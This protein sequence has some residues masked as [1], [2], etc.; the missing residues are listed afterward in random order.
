MKYILITLLLGL[1]QIQAQK[2]VEMITKEVSFADNSPENIFVARNINGSIN[3]EAYNGKTIKIE[4]TKTISADNQTDIEKGKKEL[5]IKIVEKG[6][7]IILHP[8]A[9]YICF[10]E[11]YHGMNVNVNRS[12][13][14]EVPYHFKLEY[15]IKVPKNLN[16]D[17]STINEGDIVV[18]D[19]QA[20]IVKVGNIN[21]SIALYNIAGASEVHTINGTID[22]TY[23]KNPDKKS[24][25]S[26]INGDIE[27]NYLKN[28][29][30]NVTFESMHGDL[31]TDF[32]ISDY[33]TKSEKNTSTEKKG[34]KYT[35][36]STPLVQ[37]GNGGPRFEFK[38]LNGD[39]SIKKI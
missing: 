25:Y 12:N 7:K 33:I 21:G 5:N 31:Y 37:I 29:K 19:V 23:A 27:I 11:T 6:N 13:K 28:L 18:R 20:D 2:S 34:L 15:K 22:V 10:D 39:V 24:S 26:T 16:I 32:T 4:I 38:T 3:L 9:S 36:K 1:S 35:Y 14:N 8:E 17:I 30:A